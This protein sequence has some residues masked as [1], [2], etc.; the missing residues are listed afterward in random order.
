MIR[1]RHT[2][3]PWTWGRAPLTGAIRI[4]NERGDWIASE[5][6][7]PDTREAAEANASLLAAAPELFAAA[8]AL[9][10][11][12]LQHANC[13]ECEGEGVP[14]LCPECFPRFDKARCLRRAAIRKAE[15]GGA[16]A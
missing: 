7:A 4:R 16:D 13:D 15:G 5:V 2:P 1:A 14:E 10:G 8:K 3:G 11:A 6:Q 9:E 12:E